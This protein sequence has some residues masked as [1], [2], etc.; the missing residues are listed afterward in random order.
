MAFQLGTYQEPD[1]TEEKFVNAPEA[2]L[3]RAPRD[4][5][6]PDGF[7]AMSIFPEYFKVKGKW[8]LPKDSR[9]DCVPVLEDKWEELLRMYDAPEGE[10]VESLIGTS[11]AAN[12]HK[13]SAGKA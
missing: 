13:K 7:H 10:E 5:A 1:F 4:K 3:A 8:I 12:D 2:K 9:M 6:A 11:E